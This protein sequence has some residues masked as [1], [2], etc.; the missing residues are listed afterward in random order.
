MGK[1]LFHG[2]YTEAGVKGLLKDGGS[3]RHEAVG[4]LMKSLGGKMESF[5]FAFGGSDFYVIAELPDNQAAAAGSLLVAAAGGA[6]ATTVVL[7]SPKEID[8]AVGR[9]ADYRPPGG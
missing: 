5:Y 9:T 4:K 7:L 1:Y 2:S 8:E 6:R 3:G